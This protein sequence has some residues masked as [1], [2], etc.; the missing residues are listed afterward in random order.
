[1]I[2]KKAF[3][4][5]CITFVFKGEITLGQNI[6]SEVFP[7]C[8]TDR[9]SLESDSTTAK[10]TDEKLVSIITSAFPEKVKNKI[11]GSLTLQ[12]IVDY[13]G[14]S[15]LLSV[16][17]ETNIKTKKLNLKETIKNNLKWKIDN[18]KVSAIVLLLFED[19]T[20]KVL[21]LGMNANKGVHV[22]NNK[23]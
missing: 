22:L 20:V 1:M 6:F 18:K 10:I 23:I 5:L 3:I 4:L 21:R 11:E 12:I 19:K 16:K 17:N 2:I 9:F 15:C 13:D 7:G 8:N 14:S